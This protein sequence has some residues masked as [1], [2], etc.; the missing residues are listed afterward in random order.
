MQVQRLP[1]CSVACLLKPHTDDSGLSPATGAGEAPT[2]EHPLGVVK[3][4]RKQAV[5]AL[6]PPQALKEGKQIFPDQSLC[7]SSPRLP[8]PAEYCKWDNSLN[9]LQC[10][11]PMH[12]S[13]Q[14]VCC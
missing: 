8:A 5:P 10:L 7:F 9:L 3:Q 4:R 12:S 11:E 6:H 13:S 14:T 1:G 2:L